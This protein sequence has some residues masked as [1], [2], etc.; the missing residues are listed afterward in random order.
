MRTARRRHPV[1]IG[2][3][4]A[5]VLLGGSCTGAEATFR[6]TFATVQCPDEVTVVIDRTLLRIPE[7]P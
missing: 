7:G 4:M 3:V 1:G 2:L 6:P 5:A